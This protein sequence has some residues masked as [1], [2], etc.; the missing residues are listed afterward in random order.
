MTGLRGAI[1]APPFFFWNPIISDQTH[2][3]GKNKAD[4]DCQQEAAAPIRYPLPGFVEFSWCYPF[5]EA[6]NY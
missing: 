5:L 6:T 3:A 2:S 1:T 4:I